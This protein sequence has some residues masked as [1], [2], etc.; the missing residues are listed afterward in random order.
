SPFSGKLDLFFSGEI[1]IAR[2]KKGDLH[3]L[4]EIAVSN[5]RQGLRKTYP[6]TLMA[7]YFCQLTESAVEPE[8]AE[9]PLHDLLERGLD[10][11]ETNDPNL[12]AMLHFEKQL[13][14]I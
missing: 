11:L 10:Y 7:G 2:A 5:W 6:R 14:E 1:A 8:H 3:T 13:L 12:K 4:R 9:P